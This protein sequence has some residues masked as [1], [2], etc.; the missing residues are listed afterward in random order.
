M[1][2]T[3]VIQ[4]IAYHKKHLLVAVLL[5]VSSTFAHAEDCYPKARA[6]LVDIGGKIN[7]SISKNDVTE[8]KQLIEALGL[9]DDIKGCQKIQGEVEAMQGQRE[10]IIAS[11]QK[12][13]SNKGAA[14]K[15]SQ[16]SVL[17]DSY[18]KAHAVY[19]ATQ[20]A[21]QS[22]SIERIDTDLE[23]FNLHEP[24][25]KCYYETEKLLRNGKKEQ[26]TAFELNG[27]NISFGKAL[28]DCDSLLQAKT[29]LI[30]SVYQHNEAI[31]KGA[32]KKELAD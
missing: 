18:V 1:T 15:A 29:D 24:S 9:H 13:I 23:K 21:I 31:R 12:A 7:L 17:E 20:H 4:N 25:S 22:K 2:A 16:N 19:D 8:V 6:A 3:Q 32:R 11:M 5:S 26:E 28:S 14:T 30:V 10:K 27:N